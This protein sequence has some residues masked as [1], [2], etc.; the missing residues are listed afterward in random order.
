MLKQINSNIGKRYVKGIIKIEST[1]NPGNK[2]L[3]II[4]DPKQCL[5]HIDVV[6]RGAD[7]ESY[8]IKH[9]LVLNKLYQDKWMSE[10][11]SFGC[12]FTR[13]QKLHILEDILDGLEFMQDLTNLKSLTIKLDRDSLLS[14]PNKYIKISQTLTSLKLIKPSSKM[15]EFL[16]FEINPSFIKKLVIFEAD[17]ANQQTLI[18]FIN[19]SQITDLRLQLNN[20]LDIDEFLQ[21]LQYL[22]FQVNLQI[23]DQENLLEIFRLMSLKVQHLK[24]SIN[25]Q[26]TQKN[27]Q[28]IK[29][30]IYYDIE[31]ITESLDIQFRHYNDKIER[32]FNLRVFENTNIKLYSNI[33]TDLPNNYVELDLSK[34]RINM[35]TILQVLKNLKYCEHCLRQ[36]NIQ[37]NQ[38]H[39]I[40]SE[41]QKYY[42]VQEANNSIAHIARFFSDQIDE[43][44]KVEN[45][46]SYSQN[47]LLIFETLSNF[48]E[49]RNLKINI[50]LYN[51]LEIDKLADICLKKLS[52]LRLLNLFIDDELVNDRIKI[53]LISLDNWLASDSC[54]VEE[55]EIRHLNCEQ[56]TLDFRGFLKNREKT[57]VLRV[58]DLHF[59]KK[60][61]NA[62]QNVH[63][64]D[65]IY[66]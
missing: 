24:L 7:L 15:L 5:T 59:D 30:I 41:D 19:Q 42:R 54:F 39:Y 26:E 12:Q 45:K 49:L 51:L 55:L 40:E 27:N 11:C 10:N 1:S 35:I 13:I 53:S 61:F 25:C 14:N 20:G 23:F 36:L 50:K 38:Q 62:N 3:A 47:Q 22:E 16:L 18:T 60:L 56:K 21:K 52:S 6:G 57:F 32:F 33:Q 46:L 29:P 63:V 65:L 48:T 31:S 17:I 2:E 4:P 66:E 8:I 9:N 28:S 34:C 37:V 58:K 43:F 64:V 44:K